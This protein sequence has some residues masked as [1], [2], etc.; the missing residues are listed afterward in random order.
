[1][2]P[3]GSPRETY[4]VWT[5]QGMLWGHRISADFMV[6]MR[7]LL[8]IAAGNSK[9]MV[10]GG[11]CAH[12]WAA[13]M[14]TRPSDFHRHQ[15]READDLF[16]VAALLQS[17]L[18]NHQ[19]QYEG[20]PFEPLKIISKACRFIV[21]SMKPHENTAISLDS[22]DLGT[23]IVIKALNIKQNQRKSLYFH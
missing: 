2:V 12:G 19:C 1:M 13:C 6:F 3:W 20:V 11:W 5:A 16:S 15:N 18:S 22:M 21:F 23:Q 17:M 7:I 4:L 10:L 8:Y 9:F 14:L